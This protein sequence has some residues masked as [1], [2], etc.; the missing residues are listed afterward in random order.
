MV[1]HA[2]PA[3]AH[4]LDDFAARFDAFAR[5]TPP[6]AAGF[7]Y[8]DGFAFARTLPRDGADRQHPRRAAA[9]TR[10][11]RGTDRACRG[12]RRGP[13]LGAALLHEPLRLLI[14][15]RTPRFGR[16]TFAIRLGRRR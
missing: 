6:P 2:W 3:V 9:G 4:E 8:T 12:R 15:H 1:S 13:F 16:R 7:G 14:V 10:V 5:T 11:D